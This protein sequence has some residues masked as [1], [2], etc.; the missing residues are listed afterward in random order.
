MDYL[1]TT[2]SLL[3]ITAVFIIA[4]NNRNNAQATGETASVYSDENMDQAVRKALKTREDFYT[5]NDTVPFT[6]TEAEINAIVDSAY[7][8]KESQSY[9]HSA[10]RLMRNLNDYSP[11][12]REIVKHFIRINDSIGKFYE[13]FRG[14]RVSM[15]FYIENDSNYMHEMLWVDTAGNIAL[16]TYPWRMH[17]M[18]P[19]N[20]NDTLRRF[21]DRQRYPIPVKWWSDTLPPDFDRKKFD[22]KILDDQPRSIIELYRNADS[23]EIRNN[24]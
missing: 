8:T 15:Y 22:K 21:Q 14:F 7:A 10:D 4:C 19:Q 9:Y 16:H 5:Q 17:R 1:K 3:V 11:V 18:P 20:E 13:D 12:H 6:I 23:G 2:L 24:K